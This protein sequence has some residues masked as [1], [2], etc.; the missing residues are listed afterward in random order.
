MTA[1][2]VE[3]I[4]ETGFVKSWLERETAERAAWSAPGVVSVEDHIVIGRP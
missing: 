2:R 3:A 4:A 1:M